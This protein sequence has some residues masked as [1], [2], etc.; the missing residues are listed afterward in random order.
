MAK[1]KETGQ[2]D[3]KD[4]LK[5]RDKSRDN[6]EGIDFSLCYCG[7]TDICECSD[8]T[9]DMFNGHVASGMIILNDPNNGWKKGE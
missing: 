9:I 5:L 6:E 1:K 7:H 3:F 4:W 8:P 2:I